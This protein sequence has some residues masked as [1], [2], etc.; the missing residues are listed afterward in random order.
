M[1]PT[2]PVGHGLRKS[3]PCSS[4]A[5]PS[6]GS[7]AGCVSGSSGGYAVR[8]A[9]QSEHDR[10]SGDAQARH[11][12]REQFGW[13]Q[14]R[15]AQLEALRS[16]LAGRDTLAVM[17]S[18]SGKSAIYQVAAT[19]L[20]G[21]AVVL[22]PLVALQHDQ[23]AGLAERLQTGGSEPGDA[24]VA[25]AVNSTMTATQ[26]R[27]AWAGV[28]EGI[29]RFLFLTPE[30]LA[31]EE[32]V[33]RLV[34]ARPR[35]LVVD[36]AHC[37][38][39]WGHDFR[40]DYLRIADV[41][42]RLGRHVLLALTATAAPPVRAEVVERLRME[43]VNEVVR[44]FD[45]PGLH[46]SAEQFADDQVKREELLDWVAGAPTPALVF[47]GT[48]KD[49]EWYASRLSE[50]GLRSVAYHAGQR[51]DDRERTHER[52]REGEVDIVVATS[53][54]GM[55]IDKADVRTVA[56]AHIPESLDEYY[57]ET[58]R[59]GR[60]GE[61][62]R[63]RLFYR[64]Q[65]LGL[66]RFHGS[67]R[68]DEEGVRAVLGA[69]RYRGGTVAD[70]VRAT[71]LSRRRVTAGVGLLE[72]AG[73]VD[74]DRGRSVRWT[75]GR[76]SGTEVLAAARESAEQRRA[77]GRSRLEMMR[78]YAETRDCRRRYLL[79]YFGEDLPEPCG[80]CD[81]CDEGRSTSPRAA[82]EEPAFDSAQR[83]EHEEFGPGTVM[84]EEDGRVTVLFEQA[85]YRTLDVE[86]VLREG[87]VEG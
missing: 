5:A 78:G 79:G 23:V 67:G 29:A 9:G 33:T 80:R 43:D 74:V 27:A 12:A 24:A 77:M 40:P 2:L 37:V 42:Q 55:G 61:P 16:V 71:G 68:F 21:P 76:R 41:R 1:F 32:V 51:R 20:E 58:G 52:F 11:V 34:A 6:V 50:R 87:L 30:Q 57:Q 59:A 31:D 10:S 14:L 69:V 75:A 45:R 18:G 44:G 13:E 63:A 53:A 46:L 26:V 28:A 15:P 7:L 65:D 83:V 39:S 72:D 64:T 70:L 25:V 38:S 17:P 36:E 8:V 49:T 22:S 85:G 84:Y 62:A 82:D 19:L 86:T 56:H 48:R 54:F 81:A 60:D 35:L 47:T 3:A 4:V 66:R 73:A